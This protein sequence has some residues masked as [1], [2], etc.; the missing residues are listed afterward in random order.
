M[1]L[2]LVELEQAVDQLSSIAL[3]EIKEQ[4][5][6]EVSKSSIQSGLVF[7]VVQDISQ[8]LVQLL[9]QCKQLVYVHLINEWKIR[10]DFVTL[11]DGFREQVA[12]YLP[13]CQI[14]SL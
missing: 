9:L 1:I 3:F 10:P 13:T 8:G 7:N 4:G 6:V 2:S 12:D 5:G 11:L 14:Q